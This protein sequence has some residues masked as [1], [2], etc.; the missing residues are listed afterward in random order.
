YPAALACVD[1]QGTKQ[2]PPVTDNTANRRPRGTGR[3]FQKHG[4]WYGQ[5]HGLTRRLGPVRPPGSRDGLTRA[6]AE[7]RLR[8][9]MS[10][11]TNAPPRV[12]ERVLVADVGRARI[13]E[14]AR[15]GRN[16]GN[17]LVD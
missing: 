2:K 1:R 12:A 17:T 13:R 4:S 9:R 6:M 3:I 16:V 8:A 5:W 15:K 10:E 14:L 7:A 11:L